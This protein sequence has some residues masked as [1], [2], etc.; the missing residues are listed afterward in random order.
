MDFKFFRF[1]LFIVVL[2]VML[3][4]ADEELFPLF[5]FLEV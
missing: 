1:L 2:F 5:L 3:K 4:G